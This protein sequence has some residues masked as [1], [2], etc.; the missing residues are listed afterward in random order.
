MNRL[1]RFSFMITALV[2]LLAIP[3]CSDPDPIDPQPSNAEIQTDVSAGAGPITL[4]GPGSVAAA[5][6]VS[7][8][9]GLLYEAPPVPGARLAEAACD[10]D[11]DLGNGLT[12]TCEVSPEGVVSFSFSGTVDVDGV[13][14]TISGS[15]VAGP[16]DPQPETGSEYN[17]EYIAEVSSSLGSVSFSMLGWVL[18][19]EEQ[20]VVDFLYNMTQSVTAAGFGTF[21]V[22]VL[23]S[24]TRFEISL[25]GP[26]G[27]V[28]FIE[29]NRDTLTGTVEI[30]G[31][32]VA[33][34][35]IDGPCTTI[36][37]ECPCLG[38]V[39]VCPAD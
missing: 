34:L 28:L 18:L 26:L 37:F 1:T 25:A 4:A 11:F 6:F 24:L 20:Q 2:A 23:L 19:D 3:G 39:I 31:Y 32:L 10:P 13:S 15:L 9:M 30:N 5:D 29:L 27:N 21:S 16:T 33:V 8:M 35:M 14:T 38:S 22:E 36:D 17:I 12:G 7:Q